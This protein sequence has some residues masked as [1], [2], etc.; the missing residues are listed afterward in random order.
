VE[1]DQVAS[2][3]GTLITQAATTLTSLRV[4]VVNLGPPANQTPVDVAA[5]A[6]IIKN[7]LINGRPIFPGAY[8]QSGL[9]YIPNRGVLQ[10]RPGD[11]VAVDNQGWPI[12]VSANSITNGNWT[13]TG[14]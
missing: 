13:K 2:S 8:A 1:V 3:V 7:D 6:N 4:G 14:A 5:I 9:L 11:Y 10:C 12:L